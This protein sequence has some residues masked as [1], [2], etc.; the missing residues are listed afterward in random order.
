VAHPQDAVNAG[1]TPENAAVVADHETV[2]QFGPEPLEDS[3]A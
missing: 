2:G 1:E 3:N